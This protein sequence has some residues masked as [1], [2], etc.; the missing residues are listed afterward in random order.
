MQDSA[1]RPRRAAASPLADLIEVLR[2]AGLDPAHGEL[3]DAL[4]LARYARPDQGPQST[5][6]H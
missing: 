3:A 6:P 2:G 1:P 4:W 5:T